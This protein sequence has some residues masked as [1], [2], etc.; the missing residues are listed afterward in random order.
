MPKVK[1][2]NVELYY[3]VHGRENTDWM[4]LI[5]GGENKALTERN[6]F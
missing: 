1:V 4:V 2:N 6:A 5:I 3:E